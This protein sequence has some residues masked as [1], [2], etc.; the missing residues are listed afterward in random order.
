MR[1]WYAFDASRSSQ[2]SIGHKMNKN[3]SDFN[4]ISLMQF[5]LLNFCSFIAL[6]RSALLS[7]H[8]YFPFTLCV[9]VCDKRVLKRDQIDWFLFIDC[10]R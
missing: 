7:F 10:L 3:S 9:F 6:A 2:H 5:C 1:L 8:F 4:Y